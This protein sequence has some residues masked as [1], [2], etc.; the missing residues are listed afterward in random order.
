MASGV[1]STGSSFARGDAVLWVNT[2]DPATGWANH[3]PKDGQ[4]STSMPE[5]RRAAWHPIRLKAAS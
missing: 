3:K 4:S 2:H 1:L 5:L